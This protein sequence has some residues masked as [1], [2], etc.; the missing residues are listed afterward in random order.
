[1]GKLKIATKSTK[2]AMRIMICS[3]HVAPRPTLSLRQEY[4][5][6]A[7]S[8][9]ASQVFT[10]NFTDCTLNSGRCATD[11]TS[12]RVGMRV[13]CGAIGSDHMGSLPALHVST[14]LLILMST[15][16]AEPRLRVTS[17]APTQM[18]HANVPFTSLQDL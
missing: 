2:A 14:P 6:F 4:D 11:R 13:D 18:R 7:V 1:M 8:R 17:T 15:L 9:I 10:S 5:E 12:N 16:R 3:M